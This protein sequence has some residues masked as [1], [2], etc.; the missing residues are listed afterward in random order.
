MVQPSLTFSVKS[1]ANCSQVQSIAQRKTRVSNSLSITEPNLPFLTMNPCHND[2]DMI[3]G[4]GFQKKK[5]SELV[6]NTKHNFT[7]ENKT[8]IHY[9][10]GTG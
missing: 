6:K 4:K 5:Q 3:S 2:G 9:Y 10:D 7:I 8:Q 1:L